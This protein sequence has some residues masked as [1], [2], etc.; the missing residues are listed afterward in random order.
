M[1]YA[2]DEVVPNNN[3][4]KPLLAHQD[5]PLLRDVVSLFAFAAAKEAEP[6]VSPLRL[7]LFGCGQTFHW[8][9]RGGTLR[10]F[11][12]VVVVVVVVVRIAVAVRR[13]LRVADQ[14][15][16]QI[17]RASLRHGRGGG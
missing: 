2:V 12:L 7:H 17:L 8:R 5:T 6:E 11:F 10:L 14:V 16:P 13:R 3:N 9:R 4:K 15:A 1:T